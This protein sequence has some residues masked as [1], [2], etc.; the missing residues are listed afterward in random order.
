MLDSHW[1]GQ[2]QCKTVILLKRDGVELHRISVIKP[3]F[4]N[5]IVIHHDRRRIIEV[6]HLRVLNPYGHEFSPAEDNEI[7]AQVCT[8]RF[9]E[10]SF[11]AGQGHFAE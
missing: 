3:G 1:N 9:P 8:W 6:V 10:K 2:M 5:K 7:L 4:I 11:V